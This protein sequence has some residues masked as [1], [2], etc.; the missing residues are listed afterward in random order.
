[1]EETKKYEKV[2]GNEEW[3]ANNDK[4]CGKILNLNKGFR[5][6]IHYVRNAQRCC[7]SDHPKIQ[8]KSR[9]LKRY[10]IQGFFDHKNKHETFYILNGKVLME[11][12][13]KEDKSKFR[14]MGSGE[15]Q[16]IEPYMKHRF[17]GLEKSQIIEFS[18]H[19]EEEDSYRDTPSGQVDLN[20][21]NK[22]F[23]L[24]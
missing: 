18:T 24:K 4:Y 23:N 17:T 11:I 22:D 2:W 8:S 12:W 7:I 21:L 3:V 16:V 13:N 6:S 14:V 10:K 9:Y 5:C 15:I 20:K 1:M 19:H